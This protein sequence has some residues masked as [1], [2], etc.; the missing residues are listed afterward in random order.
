MSYIWDWIKR[1]Y[2]K[3]QGGWFKRKRRNSNPIKRFSTYITGNIYDKDLVFVTIFDLKAREKNW[4]GKPQIN[5]YSILV[6]TFLNES[7]LKN[8]NR[9]ILSYT[10]SCRKI[11]KG[12]KP[13]PN[14]QIITRRALPPEEKYIEN[15]GITGWGRIM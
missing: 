12:I 6:N 10:V 2:H 9:E 8:Q 1:V 15:G 3:P 13:A 11:P 7:Y 5:I 14:F 4:I